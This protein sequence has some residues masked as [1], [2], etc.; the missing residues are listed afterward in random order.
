MAKLLIVDPSE[1]IRFVLTNL[2]RQEF[3]VFACA[4]G[5]QALAVLRR[6]KPDLLVTDLVLSGID[7]LSLLSM[8][9]Q[10]EI[11]PPTLVVSTFLHDHVIQAL[12]QENVVYLMRKPC[13]LPVLTGRI[14]ELAAAGSSQLLFRPDPRNVVSTALFEL[15]MPASRLGYSNCLE[16]ILM[17]RENPTASLSKEIYPILSEAQGV[18]AISVEKNIRDAIVDAYCHR[19]EA[20]WRR[21]FLPAPNGQIPKPTN[22]QFLS[23]LAQVLFAMERN[24]K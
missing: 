13:E 23:T 18:S 2:L 10:E 16:A 4:T 7:G 15:G 20:V 19:S 24:V 5:D 22:R 1:E 8:A 9:R 17:L 14:R 11:C 12:Q 21:Y 6:E 3:E